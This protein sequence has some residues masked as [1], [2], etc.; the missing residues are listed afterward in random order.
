MTPLP[1]LLE[2]NIPAIIWPFKFAINLIKYCFLFVV[3]I[4]FQ[5][6]WCAIGSMSKNGEETSMLPGL[7]RARPCNGCRPSQC[8]H[9]S[10]RC[11]G[12]CPL[13]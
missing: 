6:S 4:F 3:K 12:Q 2:N 8:F 5:A 13:S 10:S 9:G 1:L 7:Q 11:S